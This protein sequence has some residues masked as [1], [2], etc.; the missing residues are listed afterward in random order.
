MKIRT[1]K[2]LII[3]LPFSLFLTETSAQQD[4]SDEE[5]QAPFRV[6]VD[7]VNILATIHYKDSR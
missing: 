5:G 7:A 1:W 2:R 4:E 3:V 6:E